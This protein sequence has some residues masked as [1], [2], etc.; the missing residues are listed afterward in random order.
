MIKYRE[1]ESIHLDFVPMVDVLFNLLVFFLV[2]TSL[3]QAEREVQIALPMTKAV[4]PLSATLREI[5]VNVDAQGQIVVAGKEV[6]LDALK[7]MLSAAAATNPEQK[8]SIR[9]DRN[10]AYS[11]VVNVLDAC[12]A[13]GLQ[14]PYIDTMHVE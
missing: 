3:K 14:E 7:S 12:K 8:V 11:N 4:G 9:G 2:A 1:P 6:D 5:V 10:T 13:S